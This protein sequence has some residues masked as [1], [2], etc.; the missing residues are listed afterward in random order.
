MFHLD[1]TGYSSQLLSGSSFS[2]RQSRTSI[3][4]QENDNDLENVKPTTSSSP[5]VEVKK[6]NNESVSFSYKLHPS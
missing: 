5:I 3:D 6:S 4:S 2:F 1:D